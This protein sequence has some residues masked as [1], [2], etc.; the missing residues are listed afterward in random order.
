MQ[1]KEVIGNIICHIEIF[2]KAVK[3]QK[4]KQV[5]PANQNQTL[6]TAD[7]VA[8]DEHGRNCVKKNSP[9]YEKYVFQDQKAQKV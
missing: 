4:E 8:D 3:R 9:V 1:G 2:F 5:P 7:A 6:G